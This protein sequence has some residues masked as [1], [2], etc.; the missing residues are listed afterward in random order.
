M[1][2]PEL[3]NVILKMAGRSEFYGYEM[4]K[5]LAE[6]NIQVGIGRLYGI[7]NEMRDSGLLKD[8]WE[9]SHSGPKRRV[10][11][12]GRKGQLEREKMLMEAIR[13]VHE[14]YT[15]YL[16]DLP[17]DVSAFGTISKMLCVG[18]AER[19]RIAYA[20]PRVSDPL[21]KL[22]SMLRAE[23]PEGTLYTITPR[24]EGANLGLETTLVLDGTFED[25][26]MK[27]DYLDL[28]VV[29]GSMKSD[30]IETW[31]SEW[32]RVVGQ[33][34]S[35]AIVTPT[36]TVVSYEDPMGIGEFI[37]KREHVSSGDGKDLS[38]E[39]LAQHMSDYFERVEHKQVVHITVLQGFNPK[40]R[41]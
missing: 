24:S 36:A 13:T 1:R 15:E 10:Y 17:S 11:Q 41:P 16:L 34:G 2:T 8:R 22:L 3:K 26:P 39:L 6:K 33:D 29:T 12:I 4:H 37:E 19:A 35:L 27:D 25:I 40:I 31:L 14:F 5:Q 7:L 9:D 18:I 23:V 38:V 28:L 32:Q 20:T 30:N 21:R